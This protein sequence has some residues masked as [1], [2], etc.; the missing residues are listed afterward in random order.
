MSNGITLGDNA[1]TADEAGNWI[2]KV[3]QPSETLD[4]KA[5]TTSTAHNAMRLRRDLAALVAWPRPLSVESRAV[6]TAIATTLNFFEDPSVFDG[7]LKDLVWHVESLHGGKVY[8]R[9]LKQ[10]NGSWEASETDI[11]AA[12]SLWNYSVHLRPSMIKKAQKTQSDVTS[13]PRVGSSPQRILRLLD[14]NSAR[15]CRDLRWWLP[16]ETAK[17]T[18]VGRIGKPADKADVRDGKCQGRSESTWK[19]FLLQIPWILNSPTANV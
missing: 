7:D 12:L 6:A 16:N 2:F 18:V 10:L 15:L 17:I 5:L 1:A 4:P 9:A 14:L 11:E 13:P 8:F 3:I 19:L